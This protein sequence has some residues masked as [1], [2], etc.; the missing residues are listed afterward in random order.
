LDAQD[1]LNSNNNNLFQQEIILKKSIGGKV[2]E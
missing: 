1:A 2:K